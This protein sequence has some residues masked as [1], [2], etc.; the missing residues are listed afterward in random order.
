M[1]DAAWQMNVR[2][3]AR[4]M[5]LRPADK[6]ESRNPRVKDLLLEETKENLLGMAADLGLS[7]YKSLHKDALA[8]KIRSEILKPEVMKKRMLL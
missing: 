3:S 1:E 5:G 7:G 4:D 2:I 8:E 6:E